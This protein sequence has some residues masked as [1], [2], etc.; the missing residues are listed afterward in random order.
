MKLEYMG[1]SKKQANKQT[2]LKVTTK[3]KKQY[4]EK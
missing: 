2:A 4:S 3:P 1:K